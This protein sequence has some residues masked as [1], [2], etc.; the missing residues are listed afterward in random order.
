MAV[1]LKAWIGAAVALVLIAAGG[2]WYAARYE[3]RILPAIGLGQPVVLYFAAPDGA[4]LE[5]EVRYV[6]PGQD[7]P[8]RRLELLARGPRLGSG[9]APVLPTGARPLEVKIEGDTAIVSFSREIRERH[10]GGTTGELMTVYGIVN[11]LA[12]YPGIRRVQILVEGK[13]VETLAGHLDL[14][15][16]L[17]ADPSLVRRRASSRRF[18]TPVAPPAPAS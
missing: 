8:M 1:R 17:E 9:L 3:D 15:Q 16:P 10:W 18:G 7:N 4:Q 2:L 6:L 14:T 13:P 12:G 11:T 5:P